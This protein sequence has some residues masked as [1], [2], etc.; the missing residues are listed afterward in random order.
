MT[1]SI[2]WRRNLKVDASKFSTIS[3]FA[4]FPSLKYVGYCW[5]VGYL[6]I[7]KKYLDGQ[8]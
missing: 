1:C 3:I 5:Y 2:P 4:R 8:Q 7:R 6:K